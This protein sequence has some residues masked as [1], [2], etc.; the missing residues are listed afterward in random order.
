MQRSE[1]EAAVRC[2]NVGC[3]AQLKRHIE[4]FASRNAL[5]IDGLGPALVE[6]LVE[7]GWIRDVADL[8]AL[9][10]EDLVSLERMGEK[11]AENLLNAIESSC[12][13]PAEKVLFGLGIPHVGANVARITN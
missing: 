10:Q 8:Y 7:A 4:H 1:D 9:K 13:I 12:N 6:Q 5:N 3:P 11:S 2:V